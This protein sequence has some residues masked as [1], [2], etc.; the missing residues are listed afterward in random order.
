MFQTI[1]I[2]EDIIKYQR[3]KYNIYFGCKI[4]IFSILKTII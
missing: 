2:I 1:I 3:V 4:F